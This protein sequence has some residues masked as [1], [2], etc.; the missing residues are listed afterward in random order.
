MGNV[1]QSLLHVWHCDIPQLANLAITQIR[2]NNCD[3]WGNC[4]LFVL[5]SSNEDTGRNERDHD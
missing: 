1:C 4:S 3:E 2:C 5:L